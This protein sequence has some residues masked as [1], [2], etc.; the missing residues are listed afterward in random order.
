LKHLIKREA[1]EEAI[2]KEAVAAV[3]KSFRK[4]A[5]SIRRQVA[6][7]QGKQAG[8]RAARELLE[9]VKTRSDDDPEIMDNY[10][11][12]YDEFYD[13]A[14]ARWDCAIRDRYAGTPQGVSGPN[15][16]GTNP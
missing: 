14:K 13:E 5:A 6:V 8:E 7:R 4:D 10:A 9:R 11:Q 1:M 3:E 12:R 16:A 2:K 15:L